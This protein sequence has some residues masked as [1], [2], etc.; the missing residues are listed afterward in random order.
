MPPQ[1]PLIKTDSAPSDPKTRQ[2][3]P[4]DAGSIPRDPPSSPMPIQDETMAARAPDVHADLRVVMGAWST[5]SEAVRATILQL[6]QEGNDADY[7]TWLLLGMALHSTREGWAR[8]LRDR[9][10]R[11]S[12]KFD[13]GKQE[14]SWR[15]FTSDGKVTIASLFHMAQRHEYIAP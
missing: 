7:D 13:E 9:W 11:Q 15:S 4:E 6:I 2:N 3:S 8:E 12:A 5:L 10:S 14:K 1:L